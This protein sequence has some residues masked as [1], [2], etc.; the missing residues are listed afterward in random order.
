M[1]RRLSVRGFRTLRKRIISAAAASAFV[2]LMAG[3]MLFPSMAEEEERNAG[4]Y[5]KSIQIEAGDSLWELAEHYSQ[6]SPMS[7]EEYV[8]AL[9]QMNGLREDTIHAGNY[10]TV[11]YYEAR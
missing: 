4:P 3:Y 5:Y 1:R 7:T 11:V 2:L 9:K 6:G 8:R 10:L